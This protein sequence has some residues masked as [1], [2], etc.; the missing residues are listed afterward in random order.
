MPAPRAHA[1]LLETHAYGRRAI[2]ATSVGDANHGTAATHDGATDST[3]GWLTFPPC[4]VALIRCD[5]GGGATALSV[6]LPFELSSTSDGGKAV[7]GS[8]DTST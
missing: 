6:P 1:F 5:D 7:A 4:I 8:F 3:A 2:G